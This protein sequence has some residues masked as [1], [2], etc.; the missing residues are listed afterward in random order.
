MKS[1]KNE[2]EVM[3]SL[4]SQ[5]VV[6]MFDVLEDATTYYIVLEFCADGDLEH[7]INSRP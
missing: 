2:I 3:K 1:L 5:H 4:K 7:F 6:R